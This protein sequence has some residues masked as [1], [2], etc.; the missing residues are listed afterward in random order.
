MNVAF[1]ASAYQDTGTRVE[2]SRTGG[3]GSPVQLSSAVIPASKNADKGSY[4]DL[5][6]LSVASDGSQLLIN[7]YTNQTGGNWTGSSIPELTKAPSSFNFTSGAL[8]ASP[9]EPRFVGLDSNGT[10]QSFKISL[11][12][13]TKWE[14][15]V[16]IVLTYL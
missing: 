16:P 2:G 6:L 3:D 7:Q 4:N 10:I 14:Y 9:D 15:E 12:N 8:I 1:R 13:S 11:E 5:L